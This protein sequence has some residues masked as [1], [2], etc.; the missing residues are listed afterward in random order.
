MKN[1]LKKNYEF[2]L[3]DLYFYF[4]IYFLA[5][6]I[7]KIILPYGD[8]PDYYH[9]YSS[10]FLNFN[11]YTIHQNNY[12]QGITCNSIFLESSLF[13]IYSKI[14]PYFC[15]NKFHD[16]LER[17][18]Y[19]L[20]LSIFYFSLVFS[21]FKNIKIL[22]FLNL[23]VKNCD[24]NLH[25]F[26]CCLIYPT[27]IYYLG[28][29]SNEILLFY[30]ALIF[31]LTWK[32][33]IFSYL[34]GFAAVLVDF[35]NGLIFFLFINYFYLFRITHNILGLKKILIL[36]F[37]LILLL[38]LFERIVQGYISDYLFQ[39]DIAFFKNLSVYVLEDEKYFKYPNF[40]KLIITYFSF[41]FLTPGFVKSLLLIITT[42]FAILYSLLL[43]SG[44]IKKRYYD[45][46]LKDNNSK[47]NLINFY[48][49]ITFVL[50]TV[51]IFPTHSYIRYYI[52]IYP[53]VF[54]IFFM[55]IG[56]KRTFL[57]SMSGLIFVILEISIFRVM[58]YL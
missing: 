12:N 4:S 15:N 6:I 21:I 35:G 23:N 11:D 45:Q 56:P 32:N 18:F 42:S 27:V 22:K 31:F 13:S 39:T 3:K 16:I 44:L 24:L 50:L 52:F 53:F 54:S 37:S 25:I 57:L 43:I 17:V 36:S 10:F 47:D 40:I 46:I 30:L 7:F 49:S 48:A 2:N 58:Y 20:I 28:T 41:I 51:L 55:T 1:Y 9:R 14:S 29:R 5:F 19:G 26:F 34:L 33:Y 8:E 38:I